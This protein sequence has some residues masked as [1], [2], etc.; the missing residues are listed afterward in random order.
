M[1]GY[2]FCATFIVPFSKMFPTRSAVQRT[3]SEHQIDG[4]GHLCV[5]K[6]FGQ[7][8]SV[9]QMCKQAWA[10]HCNSAQRPNVQKLSLTRWKQFCALCS[11][12]LKL[13]KQRRLLFRKRRGYCRAAC[14]CRCVQFLKAKPFFAARAGGDFW[15]AAQ[16]IPAAGKPPF[17]SSE[18]IPNLL[19][20]TEKRP[21]E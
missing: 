15:S 5:K 19:E 6:D 11:G 12:L 10:R 7:E 1:S 18:W 21:S 20:Q 13:L 4:C 9:V 8:S 14:H 2:Y 17:I 16:F 3:R